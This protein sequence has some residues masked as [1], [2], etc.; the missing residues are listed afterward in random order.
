MEIN[1]EDLGAHSSRIASV[2][3]HLCRAKAT[4]PFVRTSEDS[5]AVV[6]T[7]GS[8]TGTP[9]LV[10]RDVTTDLGMRETVL[11]LPIPNEAARRY[12]IG[13]H[14][15]WVWLGKHRLSFLQC[16]LRLYVGGTDEGTLQFLRL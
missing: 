9:N 14:E 4:G 6:T 12:W 10:F 8:I 5:G 15:T 16:G 2:L 7:L 11:G 1:R 13:L 3:A